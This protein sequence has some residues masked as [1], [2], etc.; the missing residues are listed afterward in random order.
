[1]TFRGYEV[2]DYDVAIQAAVKIGWVEPADAPGKF[3]PTS[4]GRELREQVE[5]QTNEYF[6]R[7]WSVLTQDELD[8]LYGLLTELHEQLLAYKKSK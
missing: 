8:E 5:S 1:M 7:T 6:Y 3:R 4:K 2:D